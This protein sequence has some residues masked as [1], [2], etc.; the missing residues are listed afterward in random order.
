MTPFAPQQQAIDK[1][2]MALLRDRVAINACATG[3]GKTLMALETARAMK[4]KPLVIAPLSAHATWRQTAEEQNAPILDV[5]NL[6][7]LRSPNN[8][9]YVTSSGKGNQRTFRWDLPPDTLVII[10]EVHRGCSG[11]KALTGKMVA[12][13]KPQRIPVLL[14][15]ATPFVSPLNMRTTGYLLGLHNYNLGEFYRWCIAHGCVS[16]P[17]HSGL[18]F[19][20]SSKAKDSLASINAA[21]RDRMVRLTTE[22][23]KE[24]FGENHLI[25]ELIN[26]GERPTEEI[27]RIYEEMKNEV[28]NG[29]AEN[30][31]LVRS[32]RARQKT[33]LLKVPVIV[34]TAQDF[35][36]EGR[37][38]FIAVNFRDSVDAIRSQLGCESAL[39]IG[40]Q[41]AEERGH[42]VD[43]FQSDK[44][45][46]IVG[47]CSAGGLSI[48]LHH[49]HP[50]QQPRASILSP[51]FSASEFVQTIGRIYRAGALSTAVQKVL[52]A[53]HTIE[54]HI[55]RTLKRKA[56]NL[57]TLTDSDLDLT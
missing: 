8:R 51:G 3:T 54:E 28:K 22:D 11:V 49:K 38:V 48:S 32:L 27:N 41:S 52:L 55:F 6:E 14:M 36:E 16:S 2:V 13:L 47:T 18:I 12:M 46:C 26:L 53:E 37:S 30:N 19:P 45:H 34:E 24:F 23:L 9:K 50:H 40:D 4:T 57:E 56:A 33:E 21:I 20:A 43:L 44:V 5:V 25:P 31:S 29:G 1:Q 7:R 39:V 17:Y 10:D 15:S 42:N 35:M